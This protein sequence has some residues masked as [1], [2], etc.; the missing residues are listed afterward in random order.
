MHTHA[1]VKH[2]ESRET[3]SLLYKINERISEEI[4][5]VNSSRRIAMR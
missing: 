1:K 2:I 4:I 5:T 3:F